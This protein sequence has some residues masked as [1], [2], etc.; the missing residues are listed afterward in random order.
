MKE[1]FVLSCWYESMWFCGLAVIFGS[2]LETVY[3]ISLSFIISL[4]KWLMVNQTYC[5]LPPHDPV[6]VSAQFWS[7]GLSVGTSPKCVKSFHISMSFHFAS[8]SVKYLFSNWRRL[9]DTLSEQQWDHILCCVHPREDRLW[10]CM[11]KRNRLS[12]ST[13]WR[14]E[15]HLH[16]KCPNI[17]PSFPLCASKQNILASCGWWVCTQWNADTAQIAGRTTLY[18]KNVKAVE[19]KLNGNVL[20]ALMFYVIFYCKQKIV[21]DFRHISSSYCRRMPFKICMF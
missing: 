18:V 12:V 13:F 7:H 21:L 3:I 8:V 2:G 10:Q 6:V 1:D 9:Q 17:H 5:K 14:S 4:C 15:V 20:L 11:I 16:R 19:N